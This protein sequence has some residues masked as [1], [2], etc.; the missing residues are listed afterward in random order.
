MERFLWRL[1]KTAG[2]PDC[3]SHKTSGKTARAG[4]MRYPVTEV[5]KLYQQ[6]VSEWM[7]SSD[8]RLADAP[9]IRVSHRY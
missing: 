8:C 1:D 3:I 6:I 9:A 7:P 4:R 5:D 2:S